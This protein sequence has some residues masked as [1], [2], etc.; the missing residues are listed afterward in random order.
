MKSQHS[1]AATRKRC[2]ARTCA[3]CSSRSASAS[4]A[5]ASIRETCSIGFPAERQRVSRNPSNER[6]SSERLR[7]ERGAGGKRGGAAPPSESERG[8]GP[9]SSEEGGRMTIRRR[10]RGPCR[11]GRRCLE[12]LWLD[13]TQRSKR[14]RMPVN[15]FA[16][17]RMEPGK[18]R[19]IESM[20]EARDWQRLFIG[21]IRAGRDPRIA[22]SVKEAP[23]D[24]QHVAGF[25]DA[26]FE[27]QLTPAGI[28]SLDTAGGR[29][30]V[31]KQYFGDLP[32][33]A[34]EDAAVVNRFKTESDYARR[35]EIST[36]HKV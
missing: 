23:P 11:A 6:R 19:P 34:L 13:V 35:V 3:A 2:G 16:V 9:A 26:Y 22:P 5:D 15:D 24:L 18:Q 33:S 1:S 14:Y 7:P 30:K 20:E 25:L 36:L 27:R 4:E 8:W 10:C 12:H 32:V 31:L 28:R 21:E 17:P 29:I